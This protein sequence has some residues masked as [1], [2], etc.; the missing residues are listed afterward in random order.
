MYALNWFSPIYLANTAAEWI[1]FVCCHLMNYV[2]SV[3]YSDRLKSES[4]LCKAS[5]SLL[6]IL[7]VPSKE[8]APPEARRLS[9][10]SLG[11]GGLSLSSVTATVGKQLGALSEVSSQHI[12]W[13]IEKMR[14]KSKQERLNKL[15]FVNLLKVLE[16]LGD[17]CKYLDCLWQG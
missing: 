1:L 8:A 6:L 2:C 5:F 4:I 15:F 11:V 7:L 13:E 9:I 3:F 17:S 10:G 12:R 14:F 16:S